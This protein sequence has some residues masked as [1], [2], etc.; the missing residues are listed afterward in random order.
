[1]EKGLV[2]LDIYRENKEKANFRGKS[3][4]CF[5]LGENILKVYAESDDFEYMGLDRS[6]IVD[7]S[8]YKSKLIV[9]PTKYIYENGV[10]AGEVSRYISDR[11]LDN[12]AFDNDVKVLELLRN[13]RDAINELK[14]FKQI[15]MCDLCTCNIAYSDESG[16]HIYDT[17]EWQHGTGDYNIH[18]FDSA[19]FRV[20]IDYLCFPS[21]LH[22]LIRTDIP[23]NVLKGYYGKL[24][25][26]FFDVI[27]D[28]LMEKYCIEDFLNLYCE[29]YQ[30]YYNSEMTT[31]NEMKNYTKIL[32]KNN[33]KVDFS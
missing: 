32:K 12:N 10:I 15:D 21:Y 30:R 29:M 2:D 7:L 25:K 23:Y 19:V 31:L 1:M 33:K 16:F 27:T 26:D 13:Y 18:R 5:L 8:H 24:G 20:L 17:T 28:N 22:E 3:A 6:K 9:F 14:K 4:Y 11:A